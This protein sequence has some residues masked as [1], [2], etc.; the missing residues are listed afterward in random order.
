MGSLNRGHG[1]ANWRNPT[2]RGRCESLRD[3]WSVFNPQFPEKS[4]RREPIG[5]APQ[6]VEPLTS[7]HQDGSQIAFGNHALGF[8]EGSHELT[9]TLSISI[10]PTALQIRSTAGRR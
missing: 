10:V 3:V 5:A 4:R 9:F 8:V 6:T 7:V 1:V 2:I